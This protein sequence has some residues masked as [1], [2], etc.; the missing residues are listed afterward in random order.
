MTYTFKLARRLAVSRK[1]VVLAALL[2]IAACS[3]ESTGPDADAPSTFGAPAALQIAPRRVTIETNQR[4]QL[5]GRFVGR[6]GDAL[7]SSIVWAASGGNI[8]ADGTFLSAVAGTFQVVGRGR[9]HKQVDTSTVVVIPPKADL[10]RIEITPASPWV[11]VGGSLAFTATGYLKDSSTTAVGVTWSATG[12]TI[13]PAGLYSAGQVAGTYRVV[14][15][16]ASSGLGDTATVTVKTPPLTSVAVIPASV[17]LTPGAASQFRA[18]GRNAVGDS[19]DVAVTFKATGGTITA[20]GLYTAGSIGGSYRVIAAAAGFAD[21]AAVTLASPAAPSPSAP[22][23][24]GTG[25]AFGPFGAWDNTVLRPY[26]SDFTFSSQSIT[27]SILIARVDAARAKKV[28]LLLAMTGGSHENYLTDGVFDRAKWNAKMDTYNTPEIKAAIAAGVAD[29]TIVGAHVMDEPQ[30]SGLGDGNTWGPRGTMTKVRVDSLC[31]YVKAMFPTLPVGVA[32]N[33]DRFEPDKSYHA[34]EFLLDQYST[35]LGDVR[36]WRDAGLALTQRD[37]MGILFSINIINGGTQDRD[38][39]WDCAGTGGL[40][41]LSPSC[42]MTPQQI[43]DYS[44]VLAPAGCGLL[45]W[46][47]DDQFMAQPENQQAFRDVRA[48]VAS[49]PA[50]SCLR[51]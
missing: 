7:H 10:A 47:Y 4:V 31:T 13:D 36:T 25:F 39:T 34:C 45:M 18:Y 21:T 20:T 33:H 9:G 2:L 49:L 17:S 51:S 8:S 22:A 15:T 44:A 23:T 40:G 46:R 32:H 37:H 43:R 3:G 5:R 6:D 42:R 26:T 50:K 29:G 14:A 28:K 11:Y 24:T 12:G 16:N 38:G 19:V 41:E 1:L 35:R 48:S 30:V 27:A